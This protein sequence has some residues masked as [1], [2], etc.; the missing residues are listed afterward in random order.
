MLLAFRRRTEVITGLFFMVIVASLF[1]L[2][3]GRS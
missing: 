2:A 1:P 3:M